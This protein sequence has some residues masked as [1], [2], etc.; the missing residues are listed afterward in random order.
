M[1]DPIV[2]VYPKHGI[3]IV[4]CG[5]VE[6]DKAY[7]SPTAYQFLGDMVDVIEQYAKER[8]Q[9]RAERDALLKVYEASR[10]FVVSC[11]RMG[12]AGVEIDNANN[13]FMEYEALKKEG[14]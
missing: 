14:V 11:N 2:K 13:S 12:F 6:T 9:L 8:D 10:I 4:L 5:A 1:S 7:A 3:K